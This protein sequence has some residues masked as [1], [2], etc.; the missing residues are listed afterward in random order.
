[1]LILQI[2]CILGYGMF[3]VYLSYIY[4]IFIV[5]LWYVVDCWKV[6]RMRNEELGMRN[7]Y[8]RFSF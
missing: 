5:Y 2:F 3:I 1:M 4:G 7:V 6:G 8:L